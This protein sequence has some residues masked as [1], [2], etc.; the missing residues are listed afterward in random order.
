MGVISRAKGGADLMLISSEVSSQERSVWRESSEC[1][2][3]NA[4]S[5]NRK[6]REDSREV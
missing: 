6:A 2:V 4:V 5:R 3:S 1:H